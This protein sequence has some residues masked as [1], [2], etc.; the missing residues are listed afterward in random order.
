MP[1]DR[2]DEAAAKR[3]ALAKIKAIQAAPAGPNVGSAAEQRALR[4]FVKAAK[5]G[6]L[7]NLN[8]GPLETLA[9]RNTIPAGT[10][11]YRSLTAG[12]PGRILD[13]TKNGGDYKPGQVRSV[14][15]A[16]DLQTLGQSALKSGNIN[17]GG[18]NSAANIIAQITAME[19]LNGIQNVNKF[20]DLSQLNQEGMLGPNTR[21]KLLGYTPSTNPAVPGIMRFGAYANSTLGPLGFLPMF[22]QAGQI[23]TGQLVGGFDYPG[24]LVTPAQQKMQRTR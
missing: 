12:E 15:G 16:S 8:K 7:P 14:A 24:Q 9:N 22:L 4:E 5:T 19:K 21:Y 11:M 13:A 1:A 18:Q 3:N 17:F 23:G 10:E 2:R 6:Y 20:G